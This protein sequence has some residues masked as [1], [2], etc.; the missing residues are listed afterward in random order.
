[1]VPF[2]VA[3]ARDGHGTLHG[4]C[5]CI[6]VQPPGRAFLAVIPDDGYGHHFRLGVRR[7]A[8][9]ELEK[10]G[11]FSGGVLEATRKPVID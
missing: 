1:M 2:L 8:L 10:H 5:S 9:M 11:I 6:V 4:W 3:F 7:E